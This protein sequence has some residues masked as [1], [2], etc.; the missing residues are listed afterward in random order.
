MLRLASGSVSKSGEHLLFL[1]KEK[2]KV[3]FVCGQVA[4]ATEIFVL[5]Q[6]YC[7]WQRGA[8]RES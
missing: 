6:F 3:C 2:K 7:K 8:R 4:L 5:G 1:K